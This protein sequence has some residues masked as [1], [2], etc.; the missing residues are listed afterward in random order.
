MG[1]PICKCCWDLI[2]RVP[3]PN[4]F[5][6]I[7]QGVEQK[8]QQISQMDKIFGGS[9][10]TIIAA[11]GHDVNHGLPGVN[12]R[13][14]RSQT[15]IMVRKVRLGQVFPPIATALEASVWATRGWTFQEG[16]LSPRR[17][18]FTDNEVAVL[19][20]ESFVPEHFRTGSIVYP[21]TN[22]SLFERTMPCADEQPMGW[23]LLEKQLEEYNSRTLSWDSDIL[24]AS[25]GMLQSYSIPDPRYP[26]ATPINHV[27]G[28]P[29]MY[30]PAQKDPDVQQEH[31]H[32]P[33]TWYYVGHGTRRD[34]FPSWSWTGW[35]FTHKK[36]ILPDPLYNPTEFS[37]DSI[38]IET[39]GGLRSLMEYVEDQR[40]S[41]TSSPIKLP[42][43]LHITGIVVPLSFASYRFTAEDRRI[44]ICVLS[45]V[46][47]FNVIG[48]VFA[49]TDEML[50]LEVTYAGLLLLPLGS[51]E[52][53][54][55][56]LLILRQRE[57]CYVRFGVVDLKAF[58]NDLFRGSKPLEKSERQA[59]HARGSFSF[60]GGEIRTIILR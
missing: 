37:L 21:W 12:S 60:E 10:I 50:D 8:H 59:F 23:E 27:W 48:R 40:S 55:R 22:P 17:I 45:L 35:R 44:P 13:P 33:L 3:K 36:F 51:S 53:K 20:R 31:L 58:D 49:N 28:L 16:L 54:C 29:L 9:E 43:A 34:G 18:I 6:C 7:H 26:C 15:R 41:R 11:A 24:D 30:R 56:H 38:R 47:G 19:C 39:E 2:H 32:V 5:K 14:R 57:D 46:E 25:L 1:G 4:P 42:R 52:A